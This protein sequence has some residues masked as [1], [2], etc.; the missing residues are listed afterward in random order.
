VE[1]LWTARHAA[2][3]SR[4]REAAI[5]QGIDFEH[6]SHVMTAIF[7][8]AA[9]LEALVNDVVLEIVQPG[10][11][12]PSPRI[13]SIPQSSLP[14]FQQLWARERRL[15]VLR[16]CQEALAAAQSQQQQFSLN[17][18]P[19]KNAQLVIDLRRHFVHHKPEWQDIDAEHHFKPRL[20]AAKVAEYPLPLAPWFPNK[21][22]SAGLA[23]WAC[24]ATTRFA[25][26]WWRRMRLKGSYDAA[27]ND[28]PPP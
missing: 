28:F 10:P 19:A 17:H 24:E 16:K 7:F 15:G 25:D 3:L 23:Q 22:L 11:G 1:H 2:R 6:R 13:A 20:K 18:N 9:F 21:A 5:T 14:A 12:S 26:S 4:E 8:S 27:L